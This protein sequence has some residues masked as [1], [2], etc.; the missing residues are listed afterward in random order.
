MR[1]TVIEVLPTL[2]IAHVRCDDGSVVGVNRD[3]PGVP[4]DDLQAGD[5]LEL[6]VLQPFSRAAKARR[7]DGFTPKKRISGRAHR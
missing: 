5:V 6:E 4:F 7:A 1:G 2:G 3:T